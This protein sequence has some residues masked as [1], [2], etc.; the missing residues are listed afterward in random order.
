MVGILYRRFYKDASPQTLIQMYLTLVR[1]HTEYA[2][3]VWDPHL[4]KGID[5][6]ECVQK[7]TLHMCAKQWD[8][9][10]AELLN[11]FKVPSLGD[12][13]NY[14]SLCTIY[15]VVHELVYFSP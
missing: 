1:P 5:Q 6:L 12:R 13:R 14:L 7:F 3:Q 11:R 9:G 4:Q 8:L 15:K 2:S 10:Y